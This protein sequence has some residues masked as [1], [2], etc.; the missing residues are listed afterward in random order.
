MGPHKVG[1]PNTITYYKPPL[2]GRQ[3]Q[4]PTLGC[5]TRGAATAD[6]PWTNAFYLIGLSIPQTLVFLGGLN[7]LT[8]TG[9]MKV[10]G[11]EPN[12]NAAISA[13]SL[14]LGQV[15]RIGRPGHLYRTEEVQF[16]TQVDAKKGRSAGPGVDRVGRQYPH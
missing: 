9:I 12:T 5:E 8:T 14:L 15:L 3:G 2:N 11:E 7:T 16:L 13:D 4:L 10:A 6:D 1:D